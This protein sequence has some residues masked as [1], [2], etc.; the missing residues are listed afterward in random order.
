MTVPNFLASSF[1]FLEIAAVTDVATIIS[2]FR[3]ETVTLGSPVWTEPS[4]ALFKSPVDAN[5]R[6]LDVL[7][8]SVSAT[9]LEVRVR[10]QNGLTIYTRRMQIDA[11]GNTVRIYSGQFHFCIESVRATSEL[12]WGGILDKSPESQVSSSVYVFG[13]A[14]RTT[15]DTVDGNGSTTWTQFML[16]NGSPAARN[17]VYNRGTILTGSVVEP[18]SASGSFLFYPADMATQPGTTLQFGGRAYQAYLLDSSFSPGSEVLIPIDDSSTGT[19]KVLGLATSN[20]V[21]VA[22][23]KA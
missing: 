5:G 17:R 2:S 11:L 8:T 16:E 23:R 13:S 7:L 15:A 9:N 4:T 10:D 19:F 22:L 12:A 20:N 6:F 1:R 21:R 14:Y 3:S 18:V